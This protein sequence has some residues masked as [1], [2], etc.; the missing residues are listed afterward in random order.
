MAGGN[1]PG[2]HFADGVSHSGHERN[3]LF[4]NLAGQDFADVSG[5]SGADDPADGRAFA[6]L[7]FDRDGFLDLAVVNANRPLFQLFRNQLGDARGA[8]RGRF[9]ALRF[10]GANRD[11]RPRPDASAR[12]GYGAR[13]EVDLGDA[14]LLREHRAGEGFAAQNSARMLIGI[15]ERETVPEVRVR[16]PSGRRQ[17]ATDV[18]AGTLLTFFEDPAQAPGDDPVVR[19]AYEPAAPRPAPGPVR[20]AGTQLDVAI[21]GTAATPP[22][23]LVTMATWCEACVD[24]LP[25][26]A[27]LRETFAEDALGILGIAVDPGD[28]PDMLRRWVKRHQPVYRLLAELP[29]EGVERVR[30]HVLSELQR[31]AVPASIVTDAQGRVLHTGWGVPT[32][33]DLRRILTPADGR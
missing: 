20:W 3:H 1:L 28:S 29:G 5:I 32:V 24:D 6:L 4:L 8:A 17:S 23:L 30:R 33:S 22:R 13:V 2:R 26:V 14:T 15:G 18:A 21:A 31:D 27:L 12:D 19:T 16:W 11:A 10:E 25:Q 7:D 9:L